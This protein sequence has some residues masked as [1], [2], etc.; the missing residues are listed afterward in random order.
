V[1]ADLRGIAFAPDKLRKEIGLSF[2]VPSRLYQGQHRKPH[3]ALDMPE[4]G[5]SSRLLTDAGK[6]RFIKYF[7]DGN[8]IQM[9]KRSAE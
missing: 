6:F 4:Q 5:T 1:R 9:K 8:P 2:D 7:K 3:I